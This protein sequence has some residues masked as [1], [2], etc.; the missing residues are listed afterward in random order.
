MCV[1]IV[2]L[3]F[4]ALFFSVPHLR[5]CTST[6][7]LPRAYAPGLG[8]FASFRRLSFRVGQVGEPRICSNGT[9]L[10]C[11][12]TRSC[13]GADSSASRKPCVCL[14]QERQFGPR[15]DTPLGQAEWLVLGR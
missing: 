4:A 15:N 1:V 13:S 12:C 7:H 10:G 6:P 8:S 14:Q 2:A 5:R 3:C 9:R 11:V